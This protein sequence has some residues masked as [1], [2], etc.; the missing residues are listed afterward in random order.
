[1]LGRADAMSLS[2]M[3]K[4]RLNLSAALKRAVDSTTPNVTF[5][6]P[7]SGAVSQ[8]VS[9]SASATD[10]IAVAAVTFFVDDHQIA[11]DITAAPY[12][13][14]WNTTT[15]AN[16]AHTL[17]AI[18]RDAAGNKSTAT[19]GVTVSNDITPSADAPT[20]PGTSTQPDPVTVSAL[21]NTGGT[22]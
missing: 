20:S 17:T 4:G 6:T 8:T 13:V 14:A 16:G 22:R 2:G 15:V 1:M 18:A 5:L 7:A 9:V 10:N 3:G 11:G 19:L 21:G 12:A